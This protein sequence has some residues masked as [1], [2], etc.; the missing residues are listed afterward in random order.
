M[1]KYIKK[2]LFATILLI[3][4]IF[5]SEFFYTAIYSPAD[6]HGW[7]LFLSFVSVIGIVYAILFVLIDLIKPSSLKYTIIFNVVLAVCLIILFIWD[8]ISSGLVGSISYENFI[9][10]YSPAI[11]LFLHLIIISYRKLKTK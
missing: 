5:L 6:L 2:F 1:K 10:F 9:F 4:P 11:F 3:L 7:P 8:A